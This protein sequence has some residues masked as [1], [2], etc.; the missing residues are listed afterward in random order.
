MEFDLSRVEPLDIIF[1]RG[2][3]SISNLISKLE[4][5]TTHNGDWTHVGV[6]LNKD[7]LP[8]PELKEDELYVWESTF[9]TKIFNIQ[10]KGCVSELS[11]KAF[12]GTQVRN[13]KS[14]SVSYTAKGGKIAIGKLNHNPWVEAKTEEEK[15]ILRKQM[16]EIFT[17][18][19]HVG[20]DFNPLSLLGSMFHSIRIV[21]EII[22]HDEDHA[23]FCSEH[24]AKVFIELG[25]LPKTIHAEHVLPVD[26]L[27]HDMDAAIPKD[28]VKELIP[29]QPK[30]I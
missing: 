26:F 7:I 22:E 5:H 17:K 25:L 2:A 15:D 6:A 20:Y 27:G 14:L 4:K 10:G 8:I 11:K 9:S 21:N 24:V 1:F 3:E 23:L 12:F 18:L 16:K 28:M 13:L 29:L 19:N 30:K